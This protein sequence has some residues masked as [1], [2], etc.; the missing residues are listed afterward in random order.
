MRLLSR[1]QFLPLVFCV[2]SL[3]LG[4]R[5]GPP[6]TWIPARWDGGPLEIARRTGDKALADPATRDAIAQWYNPATLK[7]LEGSPI[8][9]LLVTLSAG[10]APEIEQQQ[11][12]L[13]R[14]YARAARERGFAILGLVY[15]G[16][17]PSNAVA[18]AAAADLEGLVADGHF[19][20]GY[21]EKLEKALSAAKSSSV[22][23]P[24]WRNSARARISR[25]SVVALAGASPSARNLADM[26][27]RGAPSSEPWIEA[28]IW[29]VRSLR[30]DQGQKAIWISYQ[31]DSGSAQEYARYVADAAVAGGRWIVALDDGLR[32]RWSKNE[33]GALTTW[34]QIV[35][36]LKFGEEHPEWRRSPSFGNLGIILDVANPDADIAD[37]Y[38][39][40]VARRQVAYRV[41]LRSQLSA[42][43]LASV[44]GVLAMDL[45]PPAE[46]ERQVLQDFAE[47]GGVVVS[48]PSWGNAP[49]EEA[50]AE[51]PAGKGRV[52]VYRD[53]DPESVARD[54]KDLFSQAEL[55]VVPFNVPSV[56][57]YANAGDGGKCGLIQLLNYS[58]SPATAITIRVSGIFKSARLFTPESAAADLKLKSSEGKTDFYIPTLSSWG[59]LLPE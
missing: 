59:V 37:E 32:A 18:A 49:K 41:I 33:A 38:M 31:P 53:P 48:G 58:N 23:I 44:R 36:F 42:A 27:I 43:G 57:T 47:N 24:I 19:P 26:G 13:I 15:P 3:L 8:N 14:E 46:Q 40:L 6:D 2:P 1:L 34:Q 35:T 52:V 22:L 4:A 9:C 51:L 30:L 54:M 11:Q 45:A 55:G 20:A 50:Y 10:A 17:D 16:A 25:G 12:K 28:N 21:I 7:L 39:N 5:A 29:R 56:I